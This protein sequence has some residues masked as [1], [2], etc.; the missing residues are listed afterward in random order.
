MPS[1][2]LLPAVYQSED[3]V[4]D[5]KSNTRATQ[6]GAGPVRLAG[7]ASRATSADLTC[8]PYTAVLAV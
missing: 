8:A 6:F 1:S 7:L 2:A 4:I 3:W 5:E